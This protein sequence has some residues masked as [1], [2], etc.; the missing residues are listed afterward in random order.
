MFEGAPIDGNKYDVELYDID[1]TYS[2]A[3]ID[4]LQKKGR[5][6]MCYISAGTSEDFRDDINLFPEEVKGSI[7]SFGEGDT[8]SAVEGLSAVAC[9]FVT[10]SILKCCAGLD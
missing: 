6:V 10:A 5:K 2:S 1:Y 4:D 7:V 3:V 9:N 8:V